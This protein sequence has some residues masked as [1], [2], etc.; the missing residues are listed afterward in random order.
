MDYL[1]FSKL[2]AKENA[3]V[4][5]QNRDFYKEIWKSKEVQKP[6]QNFLHGT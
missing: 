2:K 3:Q 5:L 6:P 4:T 1:G